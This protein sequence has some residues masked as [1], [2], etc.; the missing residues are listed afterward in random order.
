MAAGMFQ[1]VHHHKEVIAVRCEDCGAWLDYQP[2]E[3]RLKIVRKLARR[4]SQRLS[5]AE[6][7]PKG[8]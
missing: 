6:K 8:R 4:L 5:K 7:P 3:Y 1:Q 2:A